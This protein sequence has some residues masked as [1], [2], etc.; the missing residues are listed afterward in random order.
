MEN[1]KGRKCWKKLVVK[2]LALFCFNHKDMVIKTMWCMYKEKSR[3]TKTS[4]NI[5]LTIWMTKNASQ[6]DEEEKD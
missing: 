1:E 2:G 6:I 5:D 4:P 3:S